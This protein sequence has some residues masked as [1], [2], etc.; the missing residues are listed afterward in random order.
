MITESR[1]SKTFQSEG[2]VDV[3]PGTIS[4]CG[5]R[6][7]FRKRF[8]QATSVAGVC[9]V[10]VL[11]IGFGMTASQQWSRP[12]A[13]DFGGITCQEVHRLL[14]LMV[15]RQPLPP[16][17]QSKVEAHL[18]QCPQCQKMRDQ[19]MSRPAAAR[20][21]PAQTRGPWE[22]KQGEPQLAALLP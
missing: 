3:P 16:E 22:R 4:A 18:A 2:W 1:D 19:M 7:Q 17:Q 5:R 10:F 15:N 20:N 12:S 21:I 11:G 14:P 6:K 13:M 9:A 8:R